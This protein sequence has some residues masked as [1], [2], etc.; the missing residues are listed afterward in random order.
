MSEVRLRDGATVVLRPIRASDR[1]RLVEGFAHLSPESR[2]HRFLAPIEELSEPMVRYL[3]EVDHHDHEAIVAVDPLTGAGV[4]VAR[5]VRLPDRP[6]TAEAAVTVADEWQGRGVGTLLLAALSE[7]ARDEGIRT[8]TAMMLA[9]NHDMLEV[10]EPVARVR[11]IDRRTGTVE[12]EVDVPPA[13]AI[14]RL[15]ELLRLSGRT[16]ELAVAESEGER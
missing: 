2:Y 11:V 10:L 14:P 8:F 7:R 15:R 16:T 1:D 4:G 13:G 3:T 5:F 12:I 9:A 6:E